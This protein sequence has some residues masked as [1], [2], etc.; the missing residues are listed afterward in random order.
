M[1]DYTYNM[2][3]DL[4]SHVE[5][6]RIE[7]EDMYIENQVLNKTPYLEYLLPRVFESPNI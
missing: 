5:I 1:A 7:D 4:V 6:L 3:L 2:E